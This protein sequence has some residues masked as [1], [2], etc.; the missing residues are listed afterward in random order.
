MPLELVTPETMRRDAPEIAMVLEHRAAAALNASFAH[1][2]L[3]EDSVVDASV[4][5][6]AAEELAATR[7]KAI[8]AIHVKPRQSRRS[9]LLS[10]GSDPI[11][12]MA[13][14]PP[15]EATFEDWIRVLP[16]KRKRR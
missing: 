12:A 14:E 10:A 2:E 13:S 9:F 15:R 4:A 11:L 5:L 6:R 16:K 1:T 7:R 8:R 3:S